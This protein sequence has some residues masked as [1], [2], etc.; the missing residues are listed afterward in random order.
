[1]Q[2]NDLL[3]IVVPF[4]SDLSMQMMSYWA[5]QSWLEN[6]YVGITVAF[7]AGTAVFSRKK[8]DLKGYHA[9]LAILGIGIVL[10]HFSLVYPF[11]YRTFPLLSFVR[12][13]IRFF[14]IF[15]FAMACL[16]GFGLEQALPKTLKVGEKPTALSLICLWQPRSFCRRPS[17]CGLFFLT[18]LF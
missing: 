8:G 9:L 6:Y 15:T 16:S 10:G 5:R 2:Y 14:F 1:M 11:F 3:S 18:P 13:P 12:Y 4:F 7:L 17:S